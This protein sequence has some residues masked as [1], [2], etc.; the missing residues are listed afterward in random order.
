MRPM[1][2]SQLFSDRAFLAEQKA[3]LGSEVEE[4][5]LQDHFKAS[6]EMMFDHSLFWNLLRDRTGAIDHFP[7]L[8]SFGLLSLPNLIQTH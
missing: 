2:I 5:L 7:H 6:F 8:P 1:K 3:F 4:L